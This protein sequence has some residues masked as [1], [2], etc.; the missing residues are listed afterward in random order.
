VFLIEPHNVTF[1]EGLTVNESYTHAPEIRTKCDATGAF[2]L[3]PSPSSAKGPARVLVLDEKGYAIVP[4]D[5]LTGKAAPADAVLVP[6]AR[7]EGDLVVAGAPVNGVNLTLKAA[8]ERPFDPNAPKDIEFTLQTAT[9]ADGR[10]EFE[11]VPAQPLVLTRQTLFGLSG[12]QPVVPRAGETL[13]VRLGD[14]RRVATGKLDLSVVPGG[15]AKAIADPQTQIRARA[16]R[17]DPP[18]AMPPNWRDAA[19][20]DAAVKSARTTEPAL[21]APLA[22]HA[23][24]ATAQ[25]DG[26]L[27]FDNLLPGHYVM[28]VNVHAPPVPDVCGLGRVLASSRVEFQVEESSGNDAAPLPAVPLTPRVY[29]EPGDPAPALDAK[30]IA[31]PGAPGGQPLSLEKL[32]GKV[33]VIDFWASWCGP[34]I[35]AMPEMKALHAKYAQDDRVIFVGGNFD[36]KAGVAEAALENLKLPWPQA[37]LG[38]LSFENPVCRAWGVMA[39]PS[40]WIISP[41]G[42]VI[43][44]DLRGADV[45]KALEKALVK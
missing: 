25:L 10:F 9:R 45:A 42:K 3:P 29:P 35:A 21:M 24:A 13:T 39:I 15:G 34:C 8:A 2:E 38:E 17:L 43:A 4:A 31:A 22:S 11:R 6:W 20:W 1:V 5:E 40:V 41:D 7:V 18:P 26:S 28:Y 37:A 33:V 16:F 12:G 36:W 14:K 30:S 27:K 32:R 19:E 23:N 44:K